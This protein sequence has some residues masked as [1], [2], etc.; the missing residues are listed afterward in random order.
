MAK[1][2]G[3]DIG[4]TNVTVNMNMCAVFTFEVHSVSAVVGTLHCTA[5]QTISLNT[6]LFRPSYICSSGG[7]ALYS[8]LTQTTLDVVS[9]LVQR[10]R[11]SPN[12]KTTVNQRIMFAGMLSLDAAGY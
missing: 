10:M 8:G 4:R 9:M 12:I 11:R 5:T 3:R 1:S 2:V 6:R 7:R